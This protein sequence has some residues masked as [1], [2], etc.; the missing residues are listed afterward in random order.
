MSELVY[1][2]PC[3]HG[4]VR[5]KCGIEVGSATGNSPLPYCNGGPESVLDP[6]KV[7]RCNPTYDDWNITVADVLAALEEQE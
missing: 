7:L 5:G 2:Q 4:N 6:D 3:E 1:R